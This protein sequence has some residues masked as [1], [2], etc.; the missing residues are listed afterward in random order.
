[1][2]RCDRDTKD[3]VVVDGIAGWGMTCFSVVRAGLKSSEELHNCAKTA[4]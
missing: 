3:I 4:Q 1:V 2:E